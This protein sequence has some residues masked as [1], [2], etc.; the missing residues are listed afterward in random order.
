MRWVML[1]FVCIG[2]R[3]YEWP[4]VF[5]IESGGKPMQQQ[6]IY[7]RDGESNEALWSRLRQTVDAMYRL[8]PEKHHPC[9]VWFDYET[10]PHMADFSDDD[11]VNFKRTVRHVAQ[12]AKDWPTKEHA[13]DIMIDWIRDGENGKLAGLH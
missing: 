4:D 12:H 5:R 9:A 6:T 7:R 10:H 11:L 2:A 8:R 1:N 3:G 13:L